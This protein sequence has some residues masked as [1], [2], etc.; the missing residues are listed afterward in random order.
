MRASTII[1]AAGVMLAAGTVLA[2]PNSAWSISA[3]SGGRTST[4]TVPGEW[5]LEGGS[6]RV[7]MGEF[8]YADLAI[9]WPSERG[10][11]CPSVTVNFGATAASGL[12]TMFTLTSAKLTIPTTGNTFGR[13]TSDL[14]V[15]DANA[16]GAATFTG[17]LPNG[18]G[19]GGFINGDAFVDATLVTSAFPSLVAPGEGMN[20]DEFD[21]GCIT[22]TGVESLQLAW[23][24]LLTAGDSAM[25]NAQ[26]IV[27]DD[28]AQVVPL[29]GAAAMG[30]S[31]LLALGARRRRIEGQR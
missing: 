25:G 23:S 7:D 6:H 13:L 2:G 1:G 8:G 11:D 21:S 3:T 27:C 16:S 5:L 17:T 26:F 18:D 22:L 24:F 19:V 30:L 28:C 10:D 12:D 15:T 14:K 20:T 31:A 9:G 29:P 4:W